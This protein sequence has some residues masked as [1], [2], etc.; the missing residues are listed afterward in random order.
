VTASQAEQ[1]AGNGLPVH[2]A[3]AGAQAGFA[4][5]PMFGKLAMTTLPPLVLAGLR[6]ASA[7]LLLEVIRRAA[8]DPLPGRA[9]RGVFVLLALLGVSLNQVFFILG[10]SLTTAINTAVLTATI[11]VFTLAVALVLRHERFRPRALLGLGFALSGALVLLNLQKFDWRSDFVKGD[12]LLLANCLSYSLYL[13]LGRPVMARYRAPTAIAAVFLYGTLPILLVAAPSFA[14]FAPARVTPLA[15]W[16]LAAIVVLSTVLPYLLN[17]WALARTEASRVAL[18]VF[19]Q[20]L[21]GAA[22]A[23][24]VLNEQ[25]TLRTVV[26]AA[27]IFAGLGVT[28]VPGRLDSAE[29]A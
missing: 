19:L 13:V 23:I 2:L 28:V 27:L 29:V 22:L 9:D 11:P 26:A 15:W 1:S 12:L 17:S 7:A 8:R 24:V 20:P 18:Y 14:R 16:S 3:L 4:L 21:I 10:L 25:L 5:F 6:V